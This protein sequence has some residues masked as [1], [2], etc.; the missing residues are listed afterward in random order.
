MY[1]QHELD[2]VSTDMAASN[3]ALPCRGDTALEPSLPG[4]SLS[5]AGTVVVTGS[6]GSDDFGGWTT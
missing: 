2:S 3:T 6:V 4:D 1:T 5:G